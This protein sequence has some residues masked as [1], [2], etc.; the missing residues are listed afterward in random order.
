MAEVS[1]VKII[2]FLTGQEI[3]AEVISITD[4][5]I[6][7]KNPVGIQ[8]VPSQKNPSQPSVGL[9]NWIPFSDDKEVNINKNLVV[10]QINPT[11]EFLNQYNTMVGGLIIPDNKLIKA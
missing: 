2:R 4:E 10:I 3:I 11:V 5:F 1:K 8:I 9:F 7:V 6:K